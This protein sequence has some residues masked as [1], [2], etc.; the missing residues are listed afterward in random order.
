MNT[1]ALL[2]AA[3][4]PWTCATQVAPRPAE[5]NA[6]TPSSPG[7]GDASATPREGSSLMRITVGSRVFPATLRDN[8]TTKA[9]QA[10]LPLTA[11]MT[12]LN[13]NEKHVRLADDLPRKATN[14]G[15][16][17]AG[18]VMLYG[19]NTLVLFY[20]TF[21]TSYGYTPMGRVDDVSGLA[22]ALGVGDVT[23]TFEV[24]PAAGAPKTQ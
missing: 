14:P 9:F 11:N 2:I 7:G 10:M 22:A 5:A 8:A 18:D 12:E 15:T 24:A 13:G 17:H 21:S 3:S 20:E 6:S 1:S 23:V 16:I 19:E 4:L